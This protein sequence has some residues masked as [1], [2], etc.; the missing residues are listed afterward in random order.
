MRRRTVG[1]L[2]T[3][4]ALAACNQAS[5]SASP[6]SGGRPIGAAPGLYNAAERLRASS[7]HGE[8]VMIPAGP[9][10]SVRAYVVYPERSTRAPVVVA[11]HDIYGMGPWIRA[12]ADQLAAEGFIG[13]APDLLTGKGVASDSLGDP[14]ATA[15]AAIQKLD[16]AEMDRRLKAVARYGTSLPAA[17]KKYGIMGFCWGGTTVFNEATLDPNLGA[18]VVYYG[19]SP[20]AA[21]LHNVVS[22]V[23]GLYGGNDARVDMTIP[24]ADSVMKS[25]H[26]VFEHRI[27]EGAGHGFLRGQT[28]APAD[29]N[30]VAAEQAWPETVNWFRKYLG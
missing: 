19:T 7:R 20:T 12:V 3:L 4:L 6:A 5:Q 10:D 18:T 15:G 1:H 25:L 14:G 23:L 11:V 28:A 24:P 2:A 13:I 8:W 17:T 27:Y 9:G 26:K 21:A 30:H 22:P 16:A 29:P